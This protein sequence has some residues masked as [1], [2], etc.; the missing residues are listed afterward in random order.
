MLDQI[1]QQ[2][3]SQRTTYVS[4]TASDPIDSSYLE[5]IDGLGKFHERYNV[6]AFVDKYI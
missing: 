5:L 4:S 1:F 2:L 6:R 3:V